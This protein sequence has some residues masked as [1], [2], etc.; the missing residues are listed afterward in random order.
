M[1]TLD[2]A[3]A[4]VTPSVRLN[5]ALQ[6]GINPSL[7]HLD[8]LLEQCAV[9]PDFQVREMLT[10]A[11]IRLPAEVVVPKLIGELSRKEAQ[12][13]SQ[14]LHTLSKFRDPTAWQA[15]AAML[16]DEDPEVMRTA[17]YTSVA[18]VPERQRKWLAEKLATRLGQGD[19]ETQLSLS[20]ALLG[21]G[22]ELSMC[23]LENAVRGADKKAREHALATERLL[24]DPNLGFASSIK[25]AR[26]QVALG[27]TR[28]S[29]G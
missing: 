20:R 24:R 12:A 16:D 28:S 15:V 19:E 23:V 22:P 9:E 6:A 25:A 5:A 11:L 18:L 2:Q 4:D 3:F 21:L 13:R 26:K 17:W 29:K 8:T 7:L 14:A 10:W 27:K 1:A